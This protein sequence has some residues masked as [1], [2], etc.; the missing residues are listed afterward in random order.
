[1]PGV[2]RSFVKASGK[3]RGGALEHNASRFCY[4][5]CELFI[6]SFHS[7]HP[8]PRSEYSV[9]HFIHSYLKTEAFSYDFFLLI[10]NDFF[11]LTEAALKIHSYV[12]SFYSSFKNGIK[13]RHFDPVLGFTW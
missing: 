1:M 6:F 3:G 5:F 8:L 2:T 9:N 4:F 11:F 12:F 10:S 7:F 13:V